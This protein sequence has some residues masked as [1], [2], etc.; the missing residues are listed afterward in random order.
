VPCAIEK[1]K[2]KEQWQSGFMNSN[3]CQ[4]TYGYILLFFSILFGSK[5]I[6]F[7]WTSGCSLKI[8][9]S[10]LIYFNLI[11]NFSIKLGWRYFN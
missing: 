8:E 7:W 4:L 2:I 9:T 6:I 1:K 10:N 5:G 3:D 11:F